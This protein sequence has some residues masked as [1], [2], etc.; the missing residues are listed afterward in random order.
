[1]QTETKLENNSGGSTVEEHDYLWYDDGMLE[2][3]SNSAGTYT[4]T[5]DDLGRVS[6]QAGL[7]G[8]TLT[9]GYNV[10][11]QR[12]SITDSDG[13]LVSSTYDDIGRLLTRSDSGSGR[14]SK[15]QPCGIGCQN[16]DHRSQCHEEPAYWW[17]E[18]GDE[19]C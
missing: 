6:T 14:T 5:Y 16:A 11:D 18:S 4:F 10:L 1:M 7:F 9:Y 2:S 19:Y 3:A 17:S 8:K 13:G 12:N 15:C